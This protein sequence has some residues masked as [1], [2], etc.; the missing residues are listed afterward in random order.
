MVAPPLPTF[1]CLSFA[2]FSS[3]RSQLLD[4]GLP[5]TTYNTEQRDSPFSAHSGMSSLSP[6]SSYSGNGEGYNGCSQIAYTN[7][8]KLLLLFSVFFYI[9]SS[10]SIVTL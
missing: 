5:L 2:S 3:S 9:H 1:H 8:L 10:V 4:R 6:S 7:L